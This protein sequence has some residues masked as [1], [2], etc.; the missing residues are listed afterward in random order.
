MEIQAEGVRHRFGGILS[1]VMS[2]LMFGLAAVL[3]VGVMRFIV[4]RP[5]S[6]LRFVML[7]P[8]FIV[9][10]WWAGIVAGAIGLVV[11]RRTG[12]SYLNIAVA[13]F[14]IG[15]GFWLLIQLPPLRDW[16]LPEATTK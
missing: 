9:R 10:S 3:L 11:I 7:Y 14:L 15:L 1:Q 5:T 12:R 6:V 13:L 2:A 8:R 16:L 4:S